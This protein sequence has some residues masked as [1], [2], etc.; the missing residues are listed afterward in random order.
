MSESAFDH[1][2]D[3]SGDM[4]FKSNRSKDLSEDFNRPKTQEELQAELR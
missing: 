4:I 3:E 2:R 1:Y